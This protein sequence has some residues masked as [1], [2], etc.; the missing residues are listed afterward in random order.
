M[1][2]EVIIPFL[3]P[4]KHLLEAREVSEIMVNPDGSVWIEK[5]GHVQLQSEVRFEEGALLTGL[6][7]IANRFGKKLDADSPIMNLRLPD[8]SRMAALIPPVVHPEPMMTIRKF[9]SRDFTVDDLIERRMLTADQAQQLAEAVRQ[10]R[11]LLISGGTGAGK[12]TLANVVAGFI[13]E[14][15]RILILEDVAE[16]I[17]RKRHVISA[18]A[19]LNTHK[20]QI[21]FGDLLKAALRH[22]PDR[23][24]VGEIRGLEARVFLDALN[25]GHRGSLS[26]IHANSAG[27]ALRRLA[28]LAMRGSRG[29]PLRDIEEECGR[30]IDLVAHVMNHDGWRQVT[31]IRAPA[32]F[33]TSN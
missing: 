17:I 4:I 13:P 18:E 16:L 9:T 8:G 2:F 10:G 24:I 28:Q 7:V 33:T 21:G 31:E 25:T 1:S 26:T 27:D 5:G 12:T 19:Q 11:N 6:E 3:R 23:I 14:T 15:D 30:S 20:S 32:V 29:V 22:R